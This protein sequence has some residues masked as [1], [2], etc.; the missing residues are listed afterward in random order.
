MSEDLYLPYGASK[1]ETYQALLPRLQV[2]TAGEP[3]LIANMA[4]ISSALKEAF[5]FFWI[6]FYR[7]IDDRLVLGPF[8]GSLACTRISY[9]KGVCGTAWKEGRTLIVPDV[10][11][12]PGHIACNNLSRS[13]IVLPVKKNGLVTAVL[14][15]DSDRLNHFDETDAFYLEKICAL[16]R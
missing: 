3:D 16:V 12:F 10:N 2:L 14:D 5:E 1:E 9:G 8:Q 15:V 4:N 13:E 7:V 6:G 11:Q